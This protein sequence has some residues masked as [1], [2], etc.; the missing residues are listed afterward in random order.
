M[1]LDVHNHFY[2]EQYIAAIE[3][4]PSFYRVSRDN[5]G[6]PVIHSP[7]D[8]NVAVP[9]HRSVEVK[10]KAMRDEGVN[11]SLFSFT[12]PG[13]VVETPERSAELSKMVND[14]FAEMARANGDSLIPLATLPLNNPAAAEKELE[15]AMKVLGF[16]GAMVYSNVNYVALADARYEGLWKKANELKAVIHIHPTY[17]AGVEAMEEYMLMPLIGFL[18]DTTLAAAKLVFAGV[19]E[20]YPNIKWIL[21]HLGGTIPYLA[22]RL[23]RGFEN[24]PECRQHIDRPPTYYLKKFY[25]DTVNFDVKALQLAIDFAGVGQILAGSDYPH[26]IGSI[27]KMKQSIGNLAIS[28][29]DRERILGRNA[30]GVL[31]IG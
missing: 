8:Y 11:T 16:R 25:Y 4:G 1:I 15:R 26:M 22:E 6:N 10:L 30:M 24:F 20:R 18:M 7:G 29:A 19:P 21:G 13:T 12:C 27:P 14:S 23:D 31:G 17:P 2:P 3:K 5:D 9:G 28:A